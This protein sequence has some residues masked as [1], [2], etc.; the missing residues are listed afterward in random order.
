MMDFLHF[1]GNALH[2]KH[3]TAAADTHLKVT[4]L[5]EIDANEQPHGPY[6]TNV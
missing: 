5:F 1:W 6:N 4:Q 2:P 3:T